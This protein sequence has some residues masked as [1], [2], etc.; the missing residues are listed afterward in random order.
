M[1]SLIRAERKRV[2]NRNIFILIIAIITLF[3]VISGLMGLNAYKVDYGN[4]I[5]YTA[6]ENLRRSKKESKYTFLDKEFISSLKDKNIDNIQ[7]YKNIDKILVKN[8]DLI[9]YSELTESRAKDFYNKRLINIKKNLEGDTEKD[10]SKKDIKYLLQKAN[11]TKKP[12]QMD[13]AEGWK[14]IN[15]DL[16]TLILLLIIISSIVILQIFGKIDKFNMDEL[17]RA[18][19][20]GNMELSIAKV[21][22]AIKI[23]LII[24]FTGILILLIV[25]GIIYGFEGFSM[26]IQSNP[27]Y[28]YSVFKINYLQQFLINISLG[29]VALLFLVGF[30]LF[31]TAVTKNLLTGGVI[32]VFFWALLFVFEMLK[33]YEI[34]HYFANFLPI[35][36]TD[37]TMHYNANDIYKVFDN[38]YN[39]IIWTIMVTILISII[40]FILSYLIYV[41]RQKKERT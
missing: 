1:K 27:T 22:V 20:K 21:I 30:V 5:L 11:K 14:N 25:N 33:D 9:S 6:K 17:S 23:S 26:P 7:F 38:R 8:Y 12:I 32:T 10:Y 2:L 13:Y 28:L 35:K 41:F 3:S 39:S 31:V 37:F 18:T 4:K 24:Y 16:G 15:R 29:L 19:R 40:L 34:N 36:M